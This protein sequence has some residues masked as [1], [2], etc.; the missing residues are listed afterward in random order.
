MVELVA[1]DV[2]LHRD[3]RGEWRDPVFRGGQIPL[4]DHS[5]LLGLKRPDGGQ[6]TRRI[7][8]ITHARCVPA[9]AA[10]SGLQDAGKPDVSGERLDLPGF[11]PSPDA[12][13]CRARDLELWPLTPSISSL[14]DVTTSTFLPTVRKLCRYWV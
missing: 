8:A 5:A 6:Q 7:L 2:A 11:G 3:D 12:R 14:N 1:A 4:Q 9:D 10:P 13:E